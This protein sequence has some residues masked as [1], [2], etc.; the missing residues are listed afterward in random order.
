MKNNTSLGSQTR[1]SVVC[2]SG[3]HSQQLLV[4]LKKTQTFFLTKYFSATV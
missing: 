2:Y 4:F 3:S 1:A